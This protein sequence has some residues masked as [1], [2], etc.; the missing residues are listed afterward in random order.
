MQVLGSRECVPSELV[1]AY[2]PWAEALTG[3]EFETNLLPTLIRMSKRSPESVVT[4]AALL[5]SMLK[6]DL[7]KIAASLTT[8]MLSMVRHSKESVRY[9]ASP[10]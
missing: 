6:L 8:E 3:E 7:S 4:S 10:L 9:F 2:K 1:L 5:L